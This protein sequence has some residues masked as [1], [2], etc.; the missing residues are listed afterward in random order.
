MG[1]SGRLFVVVSACYRPVFTL[2]CSCHFAAVSGES[3]WWVGF[4]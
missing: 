3:P 2:F 1:S 4:V